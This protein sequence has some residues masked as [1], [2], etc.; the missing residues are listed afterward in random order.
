MDGYMVDTLFGPLDRADGSHAFFLKILR[1]SR[2]HFIINKRNTFV[3]NINSEEFACRVT[4][5]GVVPKQR[6]ASRPLIPEF[7]ERP[8]AEKPSGANF[9]AL[10]FP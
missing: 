3:N 8:L 4:E 9:A 10:F 1:C 2:G 7:L 6:A 5:E